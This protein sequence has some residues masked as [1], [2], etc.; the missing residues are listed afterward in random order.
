MIGS[1]FYKLSLKGLLVLSLFIGIA[2]SSQCRLKSDCPT[3]NIIQDKKNGDYLDEP[4]T[5]ANASFSYEVGGND[6]FALYAEADL[7]VYYNYSTDPS[8][9]IQVFL[10]NNSEYENFVASEDPAIGVDL[11]YGET[12]D[13]LVCLNYSNEWHVVFINVELLSTEVN[14]SYEFKSYPNSALPFSPSNSKDKNN[15][16]DHP[17]FWEEAWFIALLIIVSGA[18][19]GTTIAYLLFRK[20]IK[21]PLNSKRIKN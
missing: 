4:L 15:G 16:T 12:G 3:K 21:S 14:G 8:R 6:Y 11:G 20:L 10:L 18:A 13:K 2:C 9:L 19:G 7:S 17:L 5:S 1:P